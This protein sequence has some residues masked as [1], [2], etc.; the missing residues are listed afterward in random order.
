MPSQELNF[1]STPV[2]FEFPEAILSTPLSSAMPHNTARME[3]NCRVFSPI[4]FQSR[5]PTPY[6]LFDP[7]STVKGK[8]RKKSPAPYR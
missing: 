7:V 8:A 5:V 6:P 1:R 4:P 2:P 3:S